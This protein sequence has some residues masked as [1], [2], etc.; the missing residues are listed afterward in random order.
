MREVFMITRKRKASFNKIKKTIKD[1]KIGVSPLTQS[2]F[3]IFSTSFA[4]MYLTYEMHERVE[5]LFFGKIAFYIL[6]VCAVIYLQCLLY[7]LLSVEDS[8]YARLDVQLSKYN[9]VD[10]EAFIALQNTV[11]EQNGYEPNDCLDAWVK[12]EEAAMKKALVE[13]M[14]NAPQFI[15]RDL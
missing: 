5:H 3:G 4:L 8:F 2:L 1:A 14:K 9:P 6:V 15:K 7:D 12:V 10:K 13:Q 11:R